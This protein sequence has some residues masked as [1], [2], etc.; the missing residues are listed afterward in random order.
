M[1]LFVEPSSECC[2]DPPG[3]PH[4]RAGATRCAQVRSYRYTSPDDSLLE[5]LCLNRF[6]NFGVQFF[7][8]WFAPNLMTVVGGV[9]ALGAYAMLLWF[10]PEL[11][12]SLPAWASVA[13]AAMLF[14]YQ[15]MDGMDGKQARRTGGGSPLGEVT[16]HGAD[17]IAACIYGAFICDS[18]CCVAHGG[19]F[20]KRWMAVGLAAYSRINFAADSVSS[21]YTGRLPVSPI[22]S[23]ELQVMLQLT[24]LWN[25][26]VPGGKEAWG[27]IVTLPFDL[28]DW[29]LGLATVTILGSLGIVWR[30]LSVYTTCVGPRSTHLPKRSPLGLFFRAFSFELCLTTALACCANFPACHAAVAFVFGDKMIRIMSLRVSDPD[31]SPSPPWYMGLIATCAAIVPARGGGSVRLADGFEFE[32]DAFFTNVFAAGIVVVAFVSFAAAYWKL[33]GQITGCLGLPRNPFVLR[34]RKTG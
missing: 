15:S 32:L 7:P 21:T 17:A 23:Q 30:L 12:G 20:V 22:D 4:P 18:Y 19:A 14:V 25:G 1:G 27:K 2:G 28:G 5:Q 6:W 10:S 8:T 11:D 26:L 31:A 33:S 34:K 3:R 9:F 24:L 13:C 16:D 29:P